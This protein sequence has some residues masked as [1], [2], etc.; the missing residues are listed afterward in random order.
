MCRILI[1]TAKHKQ[2][3]AW[4]KILPALEQDNGGHGNGIFFPKSGKLVK[5]EPKEFEPILNAIK[6]HDKQP[7]VFHTRKT[8]VGAVN[9]E[10]TQP[11][12]GKNYTIAHNGT[13][14][15]APF[16]TLASDHGLTDPSDSR[17][18]AAIIQHRPLQEAINAIQE[19]VD[20][21][22]YARNL[23]VLAENKNPSEL[24]LIGDKLPH[25]FQPQKPTDEYAW[26][27]IATKPM[28][29]ELTPN[30][31]WYVAEQ[32]IGQEH[33]SK[34]ITVDL[35]TGYLKTD[36]EIQMVK[37]WSYDFI[38]PQKE[39]EVSH[40]EIKHWRKHATKD[41]MKCETCNKVRNYLN[42]NQYTCLYCNKKA[43]H[44]LE[45]EDCHRE[46]HSIRKESFL[47]PRSWLGLI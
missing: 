29:Q 36:K 43:N 19:L 27:L 22:T 45:L 13:V 23:V 46:H 37:P 8:S 24:H 38:S 47:E 7:F 40:K 14:K 31:T 20:E 33:R 6:E 44:V 17:L 35:K 18:M 30:G 4:E 25:A 41:S 2:D 34:T 21:T 16:K 10:N 26:E 1:Y 12:E 28:S 42:N 15:I 3:F 32:K 9:K 39:Q 11:I 5:T